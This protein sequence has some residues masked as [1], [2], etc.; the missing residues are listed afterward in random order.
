MKNME[1]DENRLGILNYSPESLPLRA[2][3]WL[4]QWAFIIE[5]S[6]D[7]KVSN[8]V[9]Q[10]SWCGC[11]IQIWLFCSRGCNKRTVAGRVRLW[12]LPARWRCRRLQEVAAKPPWELC[13]PPLPPHGFIPA[14][15]RDRWR[16]CRHL[17]T[18]FKCRR[19]W[20][21]ASADVAGCS[22]VAL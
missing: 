10:E 21:P 1:L 3:S 6:G 14:L 12:A 16:R 7:L 11:K 13:H 20:Q 2:A 5:V 19:V 9:L 22:R 15:Q 8:L 18:L 4:C 17:C